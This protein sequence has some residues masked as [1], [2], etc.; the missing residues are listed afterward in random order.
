MSGG[1]R[2]R[3]KR[4]AI[5]VAIPRVPSL[6]SANSH[7]TTSRSI[8]AYRRPAEAYGFHPYGSSPAQQEAEAQVRLLF[9]AISDLLTVNLPRSTVPATFTS[10]VDM[11]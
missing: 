5:P 2:P 1:K 9:W 8:A 3:Q 11:I 10:R 4:A 6:P 7:S